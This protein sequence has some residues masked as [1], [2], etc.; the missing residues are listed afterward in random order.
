MER[1]IQRWPLTSTRQ[2]LKLG[3]ERRLRVTTPTQGRLRSC[4][5]F[6][7][8]IRHSVLFFLS[9]TPGP[10]RFSMIRLRNWLSLSAT[11]IC[12]SGDLQKGPK[13]GKRAGAI[14]EESSEYEYQRSE[15]T[16]RA[17]AG[18]S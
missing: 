2:T 5:S 6:S 1:L 16:R 10:A 8:V 12:F 4:P 17:G 11:A 15:S 7:T 18:A 14:Q 3:R 13:C 9:R